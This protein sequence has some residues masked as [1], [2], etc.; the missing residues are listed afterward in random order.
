MLGSL[1]EPSRQMIDEQVLRTFSDIRTVRSNIALCFKAYG[2]NWNYH[3]EKRD[4]EV[5]SSISINETSKENVLFIETDY[6]DEP[7]DI[8]WE[9][10]KA[11]HTTTGESNLTVKT[12]LKYYFF[13]LL[14]SFFI[15]TCLLVLLMLY[16]FALHP[17]H[18]LYCLCAVK[19]VSMLPALP[20]LPLS[21]FSKR[22]QQLH[23]RFPSVIQS[24]LHIRVVVVGVL[25]NQE[26]AYFAIKFRPRVEVYPIQMCPEG[27][28]LCVYL[29][30]DVQRAKMTHLE[31][32]VIDIGQPI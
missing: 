11:T 29:S 18:A 31:F 17:F 12:I 2:I 23:D 28:H 27:Q 7:I 1:A 26:I 6:D 4:M 25:I 10:M 21:S 5:I 19:I 8:M 32:E 15:S 20:F 3:F 9:T 24:F 30:I 13:R 22:V 16:W 14:D